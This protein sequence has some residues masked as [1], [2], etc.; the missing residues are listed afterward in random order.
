MQ[1]DFPDGATANDLLRVALM[2]GGWLSAQGVRRHAYF[3]VQR[4]LDKRVIKLNPVP[5]MLYLVTFDM[6]QNLVEISED[7]DDRELDKIINY[8]RMMNDTD[9][10]NSLPAEIKLFGFVINAVVLWKTGD[11]SLMDVAQQIFL[12]EGERIKRWETLT[13]CGLG[14]RLMSV[15]VHQGRNADSEQLALVMLKFM[16]W[17]LGTALIYQNRRRLELIAQNRILIPLATYP[18]IR[19]ENVKNAYEIVLNFKNEQSL[20]AVYQNKKNKADPE[21]QRLCEEINELLD[22]QSVDLMDTIYHTEE[23]GEWQ[24]IEKKLN[25]KEYEFARLYKEDVEYKSLRMKELEQELPDNCVFIEYYQYVEGFF[26]KLMDSRYYDEEFIAEK[27]RYDAFCFCKID[28]CVTVKHEYLGATDIMNELVFY[29]EEM[30]KE[31]HRKLKK[32]RRILYDMLLGR[33]EKEIAG[34]GKIYI[35]PDGLILEIPFEVL[36]DRN[37]IMIGDNKDIVYV[38]T[39]RDFLR[40][41]TNDFSDRFIAIGNPKYDVKEHLRPDLVRKGLLDDVI[42]QIP[43]TEI[44]VKALVDEVGGEAYVGLNAERNLI[45]KLQDSGRI[46]MAIHGTYDERLYDFGWFAS[47]LV[48]SGAENWR[49]TGIADDRF[50]NGVITADEISRMNLEKTEMVVLSS[51][52][53]GKITQGEMA[54]IRTAFRAAGVKYVISPLWEVNDMAGTVFM[55][56][57]YRL[58]RRYS[59]PQALR[60]AKEEFRSVTVGEVYELMFRL[61]RKYNMTKEKGINEGLE[62]LKSIIEEHTEYYQ[63]YA[64]PFYWS[65][66]IC[67]QNAF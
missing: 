58:L 42:K 15:R 16:E 51:C 21:R 4:L 52:F 18:I 39:G 28:D 57:F 49:R 6:A 9:Y 40:K 33:F 19:K 48:F 43:F 13:Y 63:L 5:E 64:D 29:A 26:D 65:A 53:A 37:G 11:D 38:D 50:G 59:I 8:L 34:V 23:D 24:K 62:Y 67:A 47:A 46:H 1:G 31:V 25:E 7:I 10:Y 54:G 20:I 12:E 32:S 41:T 44:E 2:Y 35:A 56:I 22:S 61:S 45:S 60:I 55:I 30:G 17:S 14:I 3:A 27:L 36:T 66:F